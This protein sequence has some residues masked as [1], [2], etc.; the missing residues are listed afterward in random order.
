MF[1]KEV[2]NNRYLGDHFK[3]KDVHALHQTYPDDPESNVTFFTLLHCG[4]HF[5]R[6]S[7]QGKVITASG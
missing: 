6:L 7:G 1:L 3:M 4:D 2:D 5:Q